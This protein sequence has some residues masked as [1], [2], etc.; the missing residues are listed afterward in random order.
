MRE[1]TLKELCGRTGALL[2]SVAEGQ[3]ITVTIRGRPVAQLS[4]VAGR[5]TWMSRDRF[6]REVLPYQADPCLAEDIRLL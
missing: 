6:L 5:P 3:R 2:K 1:V 4:P